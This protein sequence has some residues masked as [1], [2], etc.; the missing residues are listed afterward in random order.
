MGSEMDSESSDS[1]DMDEEL[2]PDELKAQGDLRFKASD[3][4]GASACYTRALD[5]VAAASSSSGA[6]DN[7]TL[8]HLHGNRSMSRL[9]GGE[10][11]G[12]VEDGLQ[13]LVLDPTYTKGASAAADIG[14]WIFAGTLPREPLICAASP[15]RVHAQY[16]T[17]EPRTSLFV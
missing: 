12:S 11:A 2:T 15:D 4:A 17:F 8:V 5:A 6:N 10:L 16:V 7:V 14:V 13:C 9:K 1:S 3:W